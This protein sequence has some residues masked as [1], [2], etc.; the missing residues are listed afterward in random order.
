MTTKTKTQAPKTWEVKDRLYEL[1][2]QNI[3]PVYIIK[4]RRLYFFDEE[5]GFEREIKYCRNQKTVFVDEMKEKKG[6]IR[7]A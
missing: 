4:S 3:P 2:A 6:R 5:K 1:M 7:K